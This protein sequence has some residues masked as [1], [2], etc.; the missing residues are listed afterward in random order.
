MLG[1][2]GVTPPWCW[3]L[4]GAAEGH[5]FLLVAFVPGYSAAGSRDLSRGQRWKLLLAYRPALGLALHLC[6]L[7]LWIRTKP[8][9]RWDAGGGDR[10]PLGGWGKHLL[11]FPICPCWAGWSL[12]LSE[13][14][15]PH[16]ACPAMPGSRRG[17]EAKPLPRS[18]VL[19]LMLKRTSGTQSCFLNIL[20]PLE[21]RTSPIAQLRDIVLVP[22]V[23]DH[24]RAAESRPGLPGQR[25]P[26]S[27]ARAGGRL[28]QSWLMSSEPDTVS[29]LLGGIPEGDPGDEGISPVSL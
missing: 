22:K 3:A 17:E 5:G 27:S 20:A 15:F 8:G 1:C 24:Q 16:N 21:P 6:C 26:L 9:D 25:K 2:Q 18:V 13:L 29:P 7:G 11:P 12:S 19:L 4:A 28:G 14:P 10:V 23:C